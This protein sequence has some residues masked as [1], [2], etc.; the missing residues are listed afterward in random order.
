MNSAWLVRP[1]PDGNNRVHEFLENG[2]IAIGWPS[3]GD[4]AG[5]TRGE[6]KHILSQPPYRLAGLELGNAHA[7]I[8]IFVNQ[9]NVGDWILMPNGEDIHFGEVKSGYRFSED[10]VKEGYPHLRSAKWLCSASRKDLSMALRSSLKVHRTT[11]NLTHH[12][13]E[14]QAFCNGGTLAEAI[15]A[16]KETVAVTYPLRPDFNVSFKIPKD[17]T[18]EEAKRL[19]RYLSTLYFA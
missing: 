3:I 13:E 4:L 10:T 14:I 2:I 18:S 6:L 19:S 5:K 9:M 17:I 16:R 11:A 1:L 7:T 15:A 8:D 12:I